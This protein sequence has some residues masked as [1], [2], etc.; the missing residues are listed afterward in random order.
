MLE[1]CTDYI[2]ADPACLEPLCSLLAVLA[3]FS[4]IILIVL[5]C[6]AYDQEKQR[7]QSGLEMEF[8]VENLVQLGKG[9]TK[10]RY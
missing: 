1:C 10:F 8:W 4:S 6:R 3:P 9:T 2:G 5:H 7:G